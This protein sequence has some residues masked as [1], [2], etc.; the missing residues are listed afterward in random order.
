MGIGYI[1]ICECVS[2]AILFFLPKERKKKRRIQRDQVRS[3]GNLS[4]VTG[5]M[6]PSP[7]SLSCIPL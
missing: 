3:N 4:T 6:Q 7:F 1:Y 5:L 2:C